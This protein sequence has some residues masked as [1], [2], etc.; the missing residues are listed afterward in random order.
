MSRAIPLPHAAVRPDTLRTGVVK[1]RSTTLSVPTSQR[2]ELI[3]LSDRIRSFVAA[4]GVAEGHAQIWSL[5]TTAGVFINE[6]QEAL[7]ADVKAA[8]ARLVPQNCY[9]RHNDPALSDCDR[10]NG[11]A[12]LRN[13]I[14]GQSVLV[15]LARGGLVLGTWQRVILAEFD[16]PNE[17]RVFLQ[18]FGI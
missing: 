18:A 6:W 8:F 15:P 4:S 3:D 11:D 5:H 9:Y 10:R 2:L 12:H 17:R 1:V 14:V 13:I 7:L 16:G